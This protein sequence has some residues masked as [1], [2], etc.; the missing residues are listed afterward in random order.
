[1]IILAKKDERI[2]LEFGG[3]TFYYCRSDYETQLELTAQCTSERG[4]V[5]MEALTKLTLKRCVLGWE[6]VR[7]HPDEDDI[8]FDPDLVLHL[9]PEIGNMLYLSIIRSSLPI[10]QSQEEQLKNLQSVSSLSP[11]GE[12]DSV[13]SAP[14]DTQV[15]EDH[16]PA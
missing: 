6:N 5:D 14:E 11:E 2:K 12:S 7:Y 16:P 10:A 4:Q 1:M 9:P 13:E 8:P 3:S 15:T